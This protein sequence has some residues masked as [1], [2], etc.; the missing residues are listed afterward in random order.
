LKDF[1]RSSFCFKN[2]LLGNALFFALK[3]RS[4]AFSFNLLDVCVRYRMMEKM[5]KSVTLN[6][7]ALLQ[8]ALLVFI[9]IFIYA[10][11]GFAG[12]QE[13]YEV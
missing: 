2:S 12:F 1:L 9:I 10:N 6:S 5:L 7:D 3:A 11:I 13:D 4:A 8:T